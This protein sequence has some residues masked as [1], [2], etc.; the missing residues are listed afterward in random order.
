MKIWSYLAE[1]LFGFV[2]A[3][4][5]SNYNYLEFMTNEVD[6]FSLVDLEKG[7]FPACMGDRMKADHAPKDVSKKKLP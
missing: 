5:T 7:G 2:R 3:A 6:L 4:E 1:P